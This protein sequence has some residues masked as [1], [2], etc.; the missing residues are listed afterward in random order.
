MQRPGESGQN[1]FEEI[2]NL[3]DL[4]N[5]E[6]PLKSQLIALARTHGVE[7]AMSAGS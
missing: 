5:L 4:L 1:A 6:D 7:L 2:V 3:E